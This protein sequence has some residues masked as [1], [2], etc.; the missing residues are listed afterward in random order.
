MIHYTPLWNTMK[1]KSETTYTLRNKGISSSTIKN[2]KDGQPVSTYTIDRLCM[3]LNC[4]IL[5]IIA[6]TPDETSRAPEQAP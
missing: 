2:L 3:I 4:D 6:Y 5:D 1:E